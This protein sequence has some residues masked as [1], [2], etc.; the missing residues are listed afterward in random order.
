M[1][2]NQALSGELLAERSRIED[3]L[4]KV[5]NKDYDLYKIKKEAS[6][7]RDIMK[8]YVHTIDSLNTLN[9]EQM[10]QIEGLQGDL[11]EVSKQKNALEEE[12]QALTGKIQQGSVLQ[13]GGVASLGIREKNSGKQVET[14]RA[15]RTEMIKTCF[16]LRKNTLAEPGD[17]NLYI[18]IIAPNGQV[19]PANG[20][21]TGTFDGQVG[22]YS[23][24]RVVNYQNAETDL[25][26]YYMVP[27]PDNLEKGNYTVFIYEEDKRI[28]QTT[29]ALR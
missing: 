5:K 27:N 23:I 13:A 2:D 15:S 24:K 7:L 17:K 18:R 8:G 26:V 20:S 28:G 3:L 14:D 25:C 22:S 9:K 19:L 4:K 29:L 1:L 21:S 6:T 12:K 10:V 16:V 11:T